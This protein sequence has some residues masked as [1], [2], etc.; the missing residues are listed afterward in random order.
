MAWMEAL[1]KQPL[2]HPPSSSFDASSRN[3]YDMSAFASLTEI[4][5]FD[6]TIGEDNIIS[7]EQHADARAPSSKREGRNAE[8]LIDEKQDYVR[9]KYYG[10]LFH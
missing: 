2:G 5:A 6:A 8:A 9:S 1:F 10:A 4:S 7:I 3:T